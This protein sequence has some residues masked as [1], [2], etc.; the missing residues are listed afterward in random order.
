M[1]TM[2]GHV[3]LIIIDIYAF[4]SPVMLSFSFE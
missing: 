3:T 2:F 1:A 4:I